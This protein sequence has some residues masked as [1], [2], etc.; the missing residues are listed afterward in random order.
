MSKPGSLAGEAILPARPDDWDD[1]ARLFGAR[2]A[3]GGCWCMWWRLARADFVRGK[4]W[5]EP[6]SKRPQTPRNLAISLALECA[7]VL[8][9]VQWRDEPRDMAAWAGELADVTLYLLQIADLSGVNLVEAVRQLSGEGGKR[10]VKDTRNALVTGIGWIN[11][12]RN[13]GSSAA[14]VLVPE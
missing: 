2:G 4:G 6:G 13:W 7:E 3:C 14:L 1:L 9:H 12:G 5:Y 8:E 11:Y 10:Q